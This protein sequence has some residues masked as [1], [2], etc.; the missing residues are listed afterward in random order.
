M[1]QFSL[2]LT[3][4]LA[5][6]GNIMAA[7]PP[8][9]PT[10]PLSG[11]GGRDYPSAAMTM[12]RY[13]SG[14]TEYW[15]F[16]PANPPP[17]SAPVIL[18]NHGWSAMTPNAYGAWITHLARRGNIVI[19]PRYQDSLR[20]PM[21]DFTPNTIAA[22]KAALLEL[23][24]P[25]HVKPELD[26]V[27]IVGHSMGGAITP[28]L[29]AL[30]ASE[31]LP[32]PKAIC[33][34]EPGN[35]AEASPNIAMPLADF[36]KI[37]ADALALVIVGDNDKVVGDGTARLIFSGLGQI[38]PANKS[39][40]TLVSDDHGQPP[41]LA[42]HF[43]PVAMAVVDPTAA[44]A[45]QSSIIQAFRQGVE[46]NSGGALDYYGTWKL[47]DGLIDAAFFGKNRKYALGDTPE[48]RYM[49]KWS[50]GTPV[51]ELKIGP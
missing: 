13:G 24:S 49:G 43:A 35:H 16:E 48:Q 11:P 46:G 27:A 10:Q 6:T 5:I 12:H 23:Q 20:T 37:P 22:I 9:P 30:A 39:Y 29:A 26:H 28:N 33:C 42:T 32:I 14:P 4:M 38:P 34:V 2:I 1:H 36:S 3:F 21:R 50:D 41:L 18:F 17:K 8:T 40:V 51:K 31:G 44:R 19:Y 15:I 25:D 7:D 47:F 45:T